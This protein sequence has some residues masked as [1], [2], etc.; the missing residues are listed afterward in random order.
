MAGEF[1]F[2]ENPSLFGT[3]HKAH[4]QSHSFHSLNSQLAYGIEQTNF[5]IKY[6]FMWR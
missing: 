1:T 6:K 3:E 5:F 2:L 4:P